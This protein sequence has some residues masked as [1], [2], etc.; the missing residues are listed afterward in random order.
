MSNKKTVAQFFD[1]WLQLPQR[2]RLKRNPF[3]EFITYSTNSFPQVKLPDRILSPEYELHLEAQT[4]D[5]ELE[6]SV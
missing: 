1:E 6:Q 4:T 5:H 2:E 3:T